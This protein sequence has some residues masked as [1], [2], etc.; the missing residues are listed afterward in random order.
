M[1]R[2]LAW[3]VVEST[4]LDQIVAALEVK[5][6]GRFGAQSVFPLSARQ[7]PDGR[8]LLLSTNSDEP[9]FKAK[10]L[11]VISRLGRTFSGSLEEHVMFSAFAAWGKGRKAW[12]VQHQGEEDVLNL[13]T[14]GK[15]PKLYSELRDAA[16]ER[17]R[18]ENED[19][20]HVFDLSLELAR[21]CANV[22]LDADL[23]DGQAGG[24][25]ELDIGFWKRLWNRTFWWR[26]LFL[27]LAGCL[28]FGYAM[29]L[30]AKALLWLV[31]M[32]GW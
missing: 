6:T 8:T 2:S 24:F 17:Q 18:T 31:E 20:D 19:V 10:N 16:L 28:L 27:F 13:K 23:G 5:R 26:L 21:R 22:D 3:F 11:A 29:R 4:E 30:I 25:E 15:P 14:T 1:G 7:L 9:S 32:A 12:S